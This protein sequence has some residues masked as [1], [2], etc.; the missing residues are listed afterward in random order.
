M[1]Y[2]DVTI[3][4]LLQSVAHLLVRNDSSKYSALKRKFDEEL[5]SLG[6]PTALL[7]PDKQRS[8]ELSSFFTSLLINFDCSSLLRSAVIVRYNRGPQI[9]GRDPDL[10]CET[11]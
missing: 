10:C 1:H 8:S 4:Y 2:C 3:K 7:V 11:V 5:L 6:R 9:M